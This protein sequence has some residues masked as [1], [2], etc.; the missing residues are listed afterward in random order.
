MII[1][2]TNVLSEAMRP[3]P[4]PAVLT[5]LERHGAEIAVTSVTVAELLFGTSRLPTGA[6]KRALEAAIDSMLNAIDV[7]PF[8]VGEAAVYADIRSRQES[9]GIVAG[10]LDVEIAAIARAGAHSLATRNVKHFAGADVALINPWTD[11]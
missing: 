1:V 7:L 2:D 5:W 3:S 8:G 10:A 11:V 6:R 4:E 9:L